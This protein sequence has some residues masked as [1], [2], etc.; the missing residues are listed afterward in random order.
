MRKVKVICPN[1][2]C[3][4]N[5]EVTNIIYDSKPKTIYYAYCTICDYDITEKEWDEVKE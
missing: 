3:I 4:A 1:C 2:L 5:G